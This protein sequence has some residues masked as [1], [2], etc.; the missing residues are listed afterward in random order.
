MLSRTKLGRIN[1]DIFNDE[2]ETQSLTVT[3]ETLSDH[4]S[5]T[6]LQHKDVIVGTDKKVLVLTDYWTLVY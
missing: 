6:Q 5:Q 3:L 2:W 1:G 4:H